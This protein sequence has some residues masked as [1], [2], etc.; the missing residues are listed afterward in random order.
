MGGRERGCQPRWALQSVRGRREESGV[1]SGGGERRS[2]AASEKRETERRRKDLRFRKEPIGPSDF[3]DIINSRSE[4]FDAG[5]RAG[6][7][8]TEGRRHI[9]EGEGESGHVAPQPPGQATVSC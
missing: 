4:D 5:R 1:S 8:A 3:S 2:V 9:N 7:R 6:E